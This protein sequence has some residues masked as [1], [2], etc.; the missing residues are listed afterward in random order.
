MICCNCCLAWW[1]YARYIFCS[2]R[3]GGRDWVNLNL[4]W[5]EVDLCVKS[6]QQHQQQRRFLENVDLETRLWKPQLPPTELLG[7]HSAAS[8]YCTCVTLY[9]LLLTLLSGNHV[10]NMKA[11]IKE[12]KMYRWHFKTCFKTMWRWWQKNLYICLYCCHRARKMEVR[13]RSICHMS[14]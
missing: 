5:Q 13:L 4:N 7:S 9:M 2:Q 14:N 6:T 11:E 3:A 12:E 8:S 1:I 10:I